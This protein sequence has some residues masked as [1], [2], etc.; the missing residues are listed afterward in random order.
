MQLIQAPQ[1]TSLKLGMQDTRKQPRRW[2]FQTSNRLQRLSC[3]EFKLP[4][5]VLDDCTGL[6]ALTLCYTDVLDCAD[7][8]DLVRLPSLK[9]L[10]ATFQGPSEDVTPTG[11]SLL[12]P[13]TLFPRYH[14]FQSLFCR[15]LL[16]SRLDSAG[17][18]K[19]HHTHSYLLHLLEGMREAC[20]Y[21]FQGKPGI[22]C[23]AGIIC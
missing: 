2:P 13:F 6:V 8:L 16:F 19:R 14:L 23:R 15:G 1:L 20:P 12:Q 3:S 4:R 7:I 18:H 21:E 11:A 5:H 9:E 22:K 17:T 10:S